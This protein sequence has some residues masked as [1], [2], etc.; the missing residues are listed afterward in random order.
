MLV[1]SIQD[2]IIERSR[3]IPLEVLG[4]EAEARTPY[5]CGKLFAQREGSLHLGGI[6]LDPRDIAVGADPD[7]AEPERTGGRFR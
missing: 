3:A 1:A 5:R 4:D 2:A 7:L 6:D